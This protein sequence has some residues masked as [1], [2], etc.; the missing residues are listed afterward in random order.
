MKHY[1]LSA[2]KQYGHSFIT[3]FFINTLYTILVFGINLLN[4]SIYTI[5]SAEILE[6]S[7]ALDEQ[8]DVEFNLAQ[9]LLGVILRLWG[10]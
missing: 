7:V 8:F 3:L 4:L 1:K 10:N 2:I 9:G 6:I 5:M